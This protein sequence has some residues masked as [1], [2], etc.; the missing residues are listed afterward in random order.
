[1]EV[2]FEPSRLGTLTDTLT[3]V[4]PDGGEFICNLVGVGA[5]PGRHGPIAIKAG[6]NV[7]VPFKN[8]LSAS[9]EFVASCTPASMFTVGKPKE[10]IGARK[11]AA[12]G[13]SFKPVEGA[14]AAGED[15][16]GQLTIVANAP[17]SVTGSDAPL[18]WVYYL[19][20]E[21]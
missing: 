2:R 17:E 18:R 16:R 9:V 1:M 7:S 5:E 10:T 11:P 21:V 12:F 15:V 4:H 13:V 8:V 3:I 20:G 14:A 6:G 19:R